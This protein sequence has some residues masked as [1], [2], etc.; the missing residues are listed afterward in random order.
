MVLIRKKVRIM[1]IINQNDNL[2]TFKNVP[3]KDELIRH[4][5]TTMYARTSKM[6]KYGNLPKTIKKRDLEYLIQRVGFGCACKVNGEVYVLNSGLSGILN[7]QYLPTKM[8]VSNPYLNFFKT[9]D[10]GK[11]CV[12][13][14]NDSMSQ[15]IN[16]LNEK[17]ASAIAECDISLRYSSINARILT[18][19]EASNDNTKVSAERVIEDIYEGKKLGVIASPAML[20][21]LKTYPY[22]GSTDSFIKSLLE[23]RQYLVANWFI[24]LGINANYNMKRESLSKNEVDVNEGTLLP[25][26]EDMLECRKQ[27]CEEI[28]SMFGT[29]ITVEFDSAWYNIMKEFNLEL[30][31]M[32]KE[33]ELT[34]SEI[35]ANEM[36]KNESNTD[37]NIS[38]DSTKND[39]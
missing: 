24:E 16:I 20:D 30:T 29:N 19:V 4:Y 9:L 26:I 11:D 12:W 13:F 33:V 28:N 39:D 10:I 5:I 38:N 35:K 34:E 36:D 15:G 2:Y 21:T 22:N 6:F 14:K 3:T 1:N 32:E 31:G 18:L 8:I 25:L 7:E 37:T 27:A 17:Y 23:L